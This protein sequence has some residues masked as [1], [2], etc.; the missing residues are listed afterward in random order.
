LLF[1]QLGK[2]WVILENVAISYYPTSVPIVRPPTNSF[3]GIIY[4]VVGRRIPSNSSQILT[5]VK[6]P[7]ILPCGHSGHKLVDLKKALA[8]ITSNEGPRE[9]QQPSWLK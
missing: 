2:S 9:N 1:L 7:R 4:Y 5:F 6:T 3:G 8:K